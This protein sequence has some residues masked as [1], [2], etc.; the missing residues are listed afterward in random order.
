MISPDSIVAD[1]FRK[2]LD[3]G[4]LFTSEECFDEVIQVINRPKF[5]KYFTEKDL[6]FFQSILKKETHF[7]SVK[8]KISVCRDPKDDK[9][10]RLAFD[11]DADFLVTG[12]N[13]LLVL[14]KFINTEIITPR[15]FLE[16][17]NQ[18]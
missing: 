4:I 3:L 18:H 10:L 1:A 15:N 6:L 2:V 5:K 12:D 8:S 7:I 16:K 13:D 9:F 17:I 14:G 11:S